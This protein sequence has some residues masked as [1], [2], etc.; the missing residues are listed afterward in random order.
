MPSRESATVLTIS[1][2]GEDAETDY[3]VEELVARGARVLRFDIAEF[4]QQLQVAA[5]PGRRWDGCLRVRDTEVRL[6][7]VT[8]VFCWHPT[9]FAWPEG[10]GDDERQFAAAEA[11]LGLGGLLVSLPAR[12]INHPSRVADAE[13]K[14]LQLQVATCCGLPTPPTLLTNDAQAARE[15]A[16]HVDGPLAYKPLVHR[17]LIEHEQ[18]RMVYTSIV[19]PGDLDDCR[20]AVTTHLFQQWIDKAFDVRCTVVGEAVFAVAIR[21]ASDTGHRDWRSDYASLDYEVVEPPED[22]RA[23]VVDY[24]RW[25]VRQP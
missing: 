1:A 6:E 22:V 21:A 15:F 16:A 25:L 5:K 24:L 17:A 9:R 4:P 2:W 10:M 19:D 23:R 20:V 8:G 7:S 13:Y 11:R 3:V 12:W 14:P 18:L